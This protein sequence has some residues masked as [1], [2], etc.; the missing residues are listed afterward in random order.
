MAAE[1]SRLPDNQSRGVRAE[2]ASALRGACLCFAPVYTRSGWPAHSVARMEWTLGQDSGA[3]S[4]AMP[5]FPPTLCQASGDH[6]HSRQLLLS[7]Q[8]RGLLMI[9]RMISRSGKGRTRIAVDDK[10]VCVGS[11]SNYIA[12]SPARPSHW[13]STVHRGL[14]AHLA[15]SHAL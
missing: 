5:S 13:G 11:F 6:F 2:F 4:G 1:R 8:I 3:R 14:P 7:Q 10:T 9:S 15:D 12:L